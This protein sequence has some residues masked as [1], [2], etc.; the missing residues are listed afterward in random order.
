LAQGIW[1]NSQGSKVIDDLNIL[2]C[3]LLDDRVG[4]EISSPV[5]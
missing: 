3:P 1:V 2:C 5:T 4:V